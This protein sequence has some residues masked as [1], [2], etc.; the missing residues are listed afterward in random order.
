MDGLAVTV[1]L[2][3]VPE[4]AAWSQFCPVA[5]EVDTLLMVT[6]E[7]LKVTA[8]FCDDDALP[9]GRFRES[10]LGVA[11][12][13]LEPVVWPTLKLTWKFIVPDD[14]VTTWTVAE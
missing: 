3:V 6:G 13:P 14:C 7:P 9:T 5:V 8:I 10:G 2:P 12:R 4:V 1:R 11:T